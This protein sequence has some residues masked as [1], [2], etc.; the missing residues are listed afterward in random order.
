VGIDPRVMNYMEFNSPS[1]PDYK[2]IWFRG[3]DLNG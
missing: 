3:G 2:Y 1:Y